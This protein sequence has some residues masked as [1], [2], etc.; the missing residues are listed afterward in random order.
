VNFSILSGVIFPYFCAEA[1]K[2]KETGVHRQ[3]KGASLRLCALK[4][5]AFCTVTICNQAAMLKPYRREQ[6]HPLIY[7]L[8][9]RK[10]V[11]QFFETFRLCERSKDQ[12][13]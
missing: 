12:N 3:N 5:C 1:R 11:K 4:L 8:Q 6:I 2:C 10:V 7:L 13:A 9:R